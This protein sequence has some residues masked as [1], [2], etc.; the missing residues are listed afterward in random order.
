MGR[1]SGGFLFLGLVAQG[2]NDGHLVL[3]RQVAKAV[4]GADPCPVA[5]WIRK[6]MSDEENA[7]AVKFR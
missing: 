1:N 7:H 6:S 2:C 4:K 5:R 3:L